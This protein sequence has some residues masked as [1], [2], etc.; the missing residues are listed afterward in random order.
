MKTKDLVAITTAAVATAALTVVVFSGASI[1]AGN[2]TAAAPPKF[3]QPKLTLHD[4]VLSL[5]PAHARVFQAGDQPV[6]EL[7]A[8]NPTAQPATVA[9]C[10][11]MTGTLQPSPM[12]RSLPMA[13]LLWQGS[14][15]LTLKPNET[16]TLSLPAPIAL[17]P[18]QLIAVSLSDADTA[19]ASDAPASVQMASASGSPFRPAP[20]SVASEL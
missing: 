1:E 11:A 17:P 5:A 2:D 20:S 10:V 14:Q 6:F 3:D 19:T 9:V 7:T 13:S 15:S 12:M 4:V 18:N 16:Q 8:V